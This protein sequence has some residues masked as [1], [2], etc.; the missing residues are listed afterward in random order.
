MSSISLQIWDTAG[1]ERFKSLRTPFYRGSDICLLTYALDDKTSFQSL[2]GW[3]DE[4]LYYADVSNKAAFPFVVLGNKVDL[5]PDKREVAYETAADW[6][7][8]NGNL[9]Y[10]ETSAKEATNVNEAFKMAVER[11]I[12]MESRIEK[13]YTGQT[14]NLSN[15][16]STEETEHRSCCFDL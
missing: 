6:C 12:K 4:F 3:R 9:P 8:A 1:Q 14:V 13:P 5:E 11:W 2:L 16:Q 10:I 15:R 7:A